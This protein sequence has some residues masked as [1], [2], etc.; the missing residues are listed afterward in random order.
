MLGLLRG[1]LVDAIRRTRAAVLGKTLGERTPARKGAREMHGCDK[2]GHEG[3]PRRVP[4][5]GIP[6]K[7]GPWALT[8]ELAPP[9]VPF[10]EGPHSSVSGTD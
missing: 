8:L 2:G 7:G 1:H 5:N 6:E 10:A 9:P 4:V 3:K